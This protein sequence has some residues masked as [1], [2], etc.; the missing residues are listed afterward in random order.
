[1]H[2]APT[3]TAYKRVDLP[4]NAASDDAAAT[5]VL[6]V[7]GEGNVVS[8]ARHRACAWHR[9]PR[10]IA[11]S[12]L[13]G[14]RPALRRRR[15][16]GVGV[17]ARCAQLLSAVVAPDLAAPVRRRKAIKRRRRVWAKARLSFPRGRGTIRGPSRKQSRLQTRRRCHRSQLHIY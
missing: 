6:G 15:F 16:C 4:I 14:K 2:A 8:E 3:A 17:R 5:E 7:G 12:Q 10:R 1:V 9:R 13:R 11:W